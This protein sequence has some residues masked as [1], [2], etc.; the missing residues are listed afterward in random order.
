MPNIKH[1]RNEWTKT[2][3]SV[4]FDVFSQFCQDNSVLRSVKQT[5]FDK[6]IGFKK[7]LKQQPM[8]QTTHRSTCERDVKY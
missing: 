4:D 8:Q 6:S 2:P 1:G 7:T 5:A 3:D